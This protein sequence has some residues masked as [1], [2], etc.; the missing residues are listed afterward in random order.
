MLDPDD[1]LFKAGGG[2]ALKG[3]RA[4]EHMAL[5][6]PRCC[7]HLSHMDKIVQETRVNLIQAPHVLI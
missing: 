5:S 7:G 6:S 2:L 4:Q 1:N 3:P